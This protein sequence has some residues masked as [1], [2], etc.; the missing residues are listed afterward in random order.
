MV[1]FISVAIILGLGG[2]IYIARQNIHHT[3]YYASLK[4]V[5]GIPYGAGKELDWNER[6]QRADYWEI[7][8]YQFRNHITFIHK[9]DYE[10]A[11]RMKA[12][13]TAGNMQLFQNPAR[14]EVDYV[15]NEN[16]YRTYG[17]DYY[18]RAGKDDFKEPKQISYYNGSGKLLLRLNHENR[19]DFEIDVYSSEDLL[20]NTQFYAF[21]CASG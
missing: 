14:I 15:Q 20:A 12:Y 1:I 4:E 17:Q 11:D 16:K 18:Y 9:N 21:K 7:K 5:F 8:D 3:K 2:S 13:S 10:Q 19:D 6:R